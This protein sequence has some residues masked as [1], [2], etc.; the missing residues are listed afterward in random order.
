MGEVSSPSSLM[1]CCSGG[2]C[3]GCKVVAG[4]FALLS[5]L[6]TLAMLMAVYRTHVMPT[7]GLMFG[8]PEGSLAVIAFAASAALWLKVVCKLCPCG[9]KGM[10]GA[11]ACDKGACAMPGCCKD[12]SCCKACNKCPCECPKK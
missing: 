10:C 12:G 8:S 7:G 3:I 1:S 4:V 9:S 11:G 2:K 5:T 6:T